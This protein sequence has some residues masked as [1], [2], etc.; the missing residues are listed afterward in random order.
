M[1]TSS[2]AK[3]RKAHCDKHGDYHAHRW[4][5]DRWS[6]CP[7]CAKED[8]EVREAETKTAQLADF[9]W[10]AMSESG[11]RGRFREARFTAFTATTREQRKVVATC[12]DFTAAAKGG[13]WS[14]L[15]L[16]G[17]PGTGK[18]HLAAAM[19]L[20]TIERGNWARY[21]T[22]RDLIRALRA[23]WRRDADKTEDDVINHFAGV[24]LLVIDEIGVSYGT[25]AEAA[26]LFDVIDRRYQLGNPLVLISNLSLP[27]LR[28]ALGDRLYDRIR[29]ASQVVPCTWPSHRGAA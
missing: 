29:E 20:E 8:H 18:T 7:T 14:T 16:I 3:A 2:D 24:P 13:Q 27:D 22:F 21:T 4:L 9:I 1:D 5:K 17:Q 19:V 12:Q 23:T 26:Q 6:A 25:E 11:L 10:K 15:T 28:T